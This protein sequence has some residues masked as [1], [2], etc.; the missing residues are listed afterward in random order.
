[1]ILSVQFS[2]VTQSCLSQRPMN[3]RTPGFP[4]SH[5]LP[6][7]TQTHDHWALCHPHLLLLSIIPSNR[8]F[9]DESVLC[10]RWPKCWSF[11]FSISPSNEYSALI[12]FRMDR[13]NLLAI[14]G[15]LESLLQHYSS[16]ASIL[17]GSAFFMA[18]LSHPYMTIGK[19]IALLAK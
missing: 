7:I 19:I 6:E 12:S 11:R 16:E 18:Q 15:T 17:R 10:I 14:Q 1:M 4:V 3:C 2:V 8:V 13:F 9:S 5:Q